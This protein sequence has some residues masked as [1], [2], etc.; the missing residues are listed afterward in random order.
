MSME[1]LSTYDA[2]RGVGGGDALRVS[3]CHSVAVTFEIGLRVEMVALLGVPEGLSSFDFLVGSF[4]RER[5][6]EGSH[7]GWRMVKPQLQTRGQT[8]SEIVV[9]NGNFKWCKGPKSNLSIELA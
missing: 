7:G 6:F 5:R 3:T 2:V 8:E 1:K 9:E 4:L